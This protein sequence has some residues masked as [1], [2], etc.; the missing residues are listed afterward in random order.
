MDKEPGLVLKCAALI[1]GLIALFYF[2]SRPIRLLF[3]LTAIVIGLGLLHFLV[4]PIAQNRVA[5]K[6]ERLDTHETREIITINSVYW[7]LMTKLT[8]YWMSFCLVALYSYIALRLGFGGDWF[9]FSRTEHIGKSHPLYGYTLFDGTL[10]ISGFLAITG[11]IWL[12]MYFLFEGIE[13]KKKLKILRE[14]ATNS[15]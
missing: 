15:A 4:P 9:P 11:I 7:G 8:L 5:K 3:G 13:T 12:P 1:L 2:G 14:R 10:L 6:L